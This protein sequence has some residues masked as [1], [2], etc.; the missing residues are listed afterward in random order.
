MTAALVLIGLAVLVLALVQ[1]WIERRRPRYL[2]TMQKVVNTNQQPE[3]V[4]VQANLPA[5]AGTDDLWVEMEKAGIA[6]QSRM[7]SINQEILDVVAEEGA[8]IAARKAEVDA[9]RVRHREDRVRRRIAKAQ[10]KPITEVTDEEV[11]AAMRHA[12][13]VAGKE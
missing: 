6:A 9:E 13:L 5:R 10:R 4:T 11:Q 8:K 1:A 7:Q 3:T 2:I 12:Q